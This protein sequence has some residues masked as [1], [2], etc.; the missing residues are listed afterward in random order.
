[1][2]E[3][4]PTAR[5]NGLGVFSKVLAI[6]KREYL[7]VV[8]TK[9]FLFGVIAMP[10]MMS[11]SI[12]MQEIAHDTSDKTFVV[13][14]RTPGQVLYPAVVAAVEERN[15]EDVFN[16]AGK[17]V[18]GAYQ[19]E[20]V[21]P[22]SNMEQQRLE[23]SQ[24]VNGGEIYGFL[25]I[26]KDVLKPDIQDFAAK[27]DNAII[28]YTA[29]SAVFSN[30]EG[31]VQ[32][33][34][35]PQVFLRRAKLYGMDEQKLYSMLVPPLVVS[36]GLSRENAATGAVTAEA[37]SDQAATFFVPFGMVMLMFMIVLLGS[38]PMVQ[39]I[40]EEKQQRIIEVLLGS[41][42]P[43]QLML[44]KLIGMVGTSLT[45]MGIYMI[46]GIYAVH[47]FQVTDYV[48]PQLMVWFVVL[49]V[50]SV[51]MF[52]SIYIAIGAAVQDL[53]EA[54]SLIL[55]VNLVAVVPIFMIIS[56]LENPSR[57]LAKALT[58]IPTTAPMVTIA[59]MA[60][61][62]GISAMETAGAVA[63]TLVGTLICVFAAG[64]IFRVGVLSTGKRPTFRKLLSWI[65]AP[66]RAAV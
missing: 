15:K 29:K 21:A 14:D 9:A 64:R 26:G 51:A 50:L 61:R 32:K 24:R 13:V 39:A 18:E 65:I 57:P 40:M 23:L 55:P 66:E 16:K 6:A 30:F 7:S 22:S 62:P 52:G 37:D 1:L 42:T 54:Q 53:K 20:Q 36:K 8:K 56:V 33:G 47:R 19:V 44:G 35:P 4:M 10:I 12:F 38:I 17:K 49:T 48:P 3:Q 58:F 34:L 28:R 5:S 63:A 11:G 46:A 41:V 45:L 25:E 60:V 43:S 59:R 27:R 31:L 2:P